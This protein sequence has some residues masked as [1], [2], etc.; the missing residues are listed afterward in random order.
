MHFCTF[1]V[2]TDSKADV[3]KMLREWTSM[4]EAHD[5]GRGEAVA[6]GAIGLNYAP[7]SDTGEALGLPA[8]ALTLTI[9]FGPSFFLKDGKD[10]FGIADKRPA[11]RRSA[12]FPNETMDPAQCGGDI[13][14]Q[15]C[16][17]DPQVAVHAIRNLAR[18]GFGT[19]AVRYSQL[20]FAG[21]PRPLANKAPREIC[22]FWTEPTTSRPKTPTSSM[23]RSGWPTATVRP[24]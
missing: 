16:A 6:D 22:S 1:D 24:G 18:V 15:A 12:Q 21:P 10:R 5:R 20:G 4:A 8:S 23:S 7:P 14:V 17:N 9:G 19:V 13:V 2:T 11:P 3:V